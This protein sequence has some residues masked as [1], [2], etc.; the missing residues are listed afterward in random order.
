[1]MTQEEFMDV[2]ALGRQ[3]WTIT[4]IAAAVGRHPDTVAKWLKAGGPPARRQ[5]AKTVID[6]RWARRIEELLAR[7]R[8]LL[9]TSIFRLLVAEGFPASYPTLV[10]H[11]GSVRGPRR[12]RT[13][14]V[15]VPI[16]TLP[17]EEA[18]A[19][20]SDCGDWGERFGLG[21]LHCFG[22][23]VCWSRHR[24]W[25]VASSVDRAYSLEGLV[26]FFEDAGGVPGRVRIDKMARWS[27]A[28][29]PGWCCTRR[30][31]SSPPPTGSAWPAAGLGT[32]PARARSSGPS[33]NSR[34]P[35]WRSWCST[36]WLDRRTERSCRPL[37]GHG[38]HPRPHRVTGQPPADRLDR[39]Q[40]LLGPLPGGRYDTARREPRR[41][42]RVPLIEV[43]G[44]RYSV[45][46][47]LAGQLVELRLPV[48]ATTLE[49]RCGGQVI[50][51]HTL[52]G[53]GQT[54]WDPA[55]R[56]AVERLAVGRH[57]PARHLRVVADPPAGTAELELGPGDD[58]VATPDLA[59]RY[60]LDRNERPGP[61]RPRA[62]CTSS[63]KTTSAPSGPPEPP[64]SCPA[65]W[66]EPAPTAHHAQFL[67]ELVAAEAAATRNRRMAARLRFAHFPTRRTLAEFDFDFQPSVDRKLI[68]DLGAL[69]F[70]AEGRPIL[71]LGQPGCGKSHPAIAL[72]TLAV[73]AGYRG[74]FTSAADLVATISGAYTDGTFP[75]KIR[76]YTGPRVLVID[77]LGLTPMDRAPGNAFFQVVN[78]RYDNGST[79][80]VTTNQGLPAWGEL[81]GDPVVAAAILD[82][83]L[84]RAVVINIKGPSWRLREHQGLV[85]RT[86]EGWALGSDPRSQALNSPNF[87]D[88]KCRSSVIAHRR[89]RQLLPVTRVSESLA[90][91]AAPPM[92]LL[93]PGLG[94]RP[95]GPGTSQDL[96]RWRPRRPAW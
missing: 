56:A 18:Q 73:E 37:A 85:D 62:A 64:R 83:L 92:P 59:V 69:R 3:G 75:T 2:V 30:R 42:G 96:L 63:S 51:R 94:E 41:V 1:M 84:H 72:A 10:R 78:R 60:D 43:D 39:E 79:T 24:F 90:G 4:D 61:P 49:I 54:V 6:Q 82:R 25:W 13:T 48:A 7:N 32:P 74:Y 28:P 29:I 53:A 35:S 27:R 80:I 89:R 40:P 19:D 68:A 58:Q 38:V 50:A 5:V 22:A 23:I 20:W 71:L 77:D 88:Q 11:L 16:Q 55:P 67:A 21:P 31:G 66:T 91:P 95:Q 52:A 57:R 9:A 86:R 34:K 15:T 93:A 44:A 36:P 45:P 87:V 17:G 47:E 26:R 33:A 14:S 76:T 70:V 81:F 12:G 8:N 65:C 46:P